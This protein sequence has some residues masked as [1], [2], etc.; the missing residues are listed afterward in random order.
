MPYKGRYNKLR[1]SLGV[2]LL[3]RNYALVVDS[4]ASIP[5]EEVNNRSI[6]VWRLPI[7]IDDNRYT[8]SIS[9]RTLT[10]LYKQNKIGSEPE[11]FGDVQLRKSIHD[12][13]IEFIVPNHDLVVVQ[14]ASRDFTSIYSN[15]EAVTSTIYTES[16]EL[17]DKQGI[18]KPLVVQLLDSG[19]ISAGQGLVTLFTDNLLRTET[20][21]NDIKS[22]LKKFKNSVKNY[23]IVRDNLFIRRRLKEKGKR[24][25][26]LPVALMANVLKLHPIGLFADGNID[27][28]GQSAFGFQRA[29]GR[30]LKYCIIQVQNGLLIP[31]VNMSYAGDLREVKN[32]P[33]FR[34]L[35]VQCAKKDIELHISA[36]PLASSANLGVGGFSLGIAPTDQ[37]AKPK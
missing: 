13:L 7:M 3:S 32:H 28:M 27:V 4:V 16:R 29:L 9:E 21:I 37:D 30:L 23:V 1:L 5:E 22:E 35:T 12:Y 8:D 33:L 17:R 11:Q 19:E 25:L 24:A 10:N 34:T 18:E 6:K 14:T 15:C 31:I 20:P 36:M 26:P 2:I